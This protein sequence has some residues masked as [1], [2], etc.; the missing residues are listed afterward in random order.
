VTPSG[1][2]TQRGPGYVE[3]GPLVAYPGIDLQAGYNDNLHLTNANVISSSL[4]VISPYVKLEAKVGASVY[5]IQYR[6]DFLRYYD[7]P[8][9][10]YASHL[11]QGN[12]RI[13]F[14]ARNDMRLR[15]EERLSSDPRGSTDRPLS[16]SPDSWRQATLYAMYGHGAT[17]APGRLEFDGS[18]L[19]RRYTNNRDETAGSD[20]NVIDAGAT[21]F[22]RIAPK[23]RVFVQAR[24]ALIDYPQPVTTQSSTE[25]RYFVGA[26]W[27]ATVQTTGYAKFGL[28]E[29]NFKGGGLASQSEPSWDL[30]V[31]WSPLSYS[32]V[33]VSLLKT[34]VES[35]GVGDAV[36]STR[37][38]VGWTHAWNSRLNHNLYWMK[39]NDDYIESFPT[40]KDDTNTLGLKFNYQFQRW[41]RLGAEF[42]HTERDSS[43]AQYLYRR[44][45]L[46]FTL[47]GTL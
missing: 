26:Q 1:A 33:D 30:G 23:T 32:V 42:A 5:D 22:W 15:I 43:D 7:S 31:R 47:G 25:T 19:E 36:V 18:Y 8:A 6:S 24:R 21:F 29:K 16:A 41:L 38:S 13:V 45:L 2:S 44:N 12:A 4:S 14:D 3:L 17:G 37:S 11:L 34:Y 20:K 39:S 40:R 35:T 27:E 10:S 28:M 46:L 9:D